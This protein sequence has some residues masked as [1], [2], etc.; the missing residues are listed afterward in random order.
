MNDNKNSQQGSQGYYANKGPRTKVGVE[1]NARRW[2]GRSRVVRAGAA[3]R[4][5]HGITEPGF[6]RALA[7][8]GEARRI[9]WAFELGRT[10]KGTEE[11][12]ALVSELSQIEAPL[13]RRTVGAEVNRTVGNA[14]AFVIVDPERQVVA[15]DE[16]H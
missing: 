2:A 9:V 8:N 16:R 13:G 5:V 10:C 1:R 12:S 6:A 7:P 4:V 3:V 14:T 15:V 11:G